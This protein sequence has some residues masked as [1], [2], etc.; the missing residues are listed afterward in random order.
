MKDHNIKFNILQGEIETIQG[1]IVG[2]LIIQLEAN[3]NELNKIK[4]GLAQ[5]DIKIEVVGYG[6]RIY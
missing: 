1:N 4:N 3:N 5:R 6:N 2:R